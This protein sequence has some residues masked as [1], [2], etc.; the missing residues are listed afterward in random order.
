MHMFLSTIN[1][2]FNTYQNSISSIDKISIQISKKKKKSWSQSIINFPRTFAWDIHQATPLVEIHSWVVTLQPCHIKSRRVGNR[3]NGV[4][5]PK[6]VRNKQ[7]V[8]VRNQAIPARTIDGDFQ[9][10]TNRYIIGGIL[11]ISLLQ[12]LIRGQICIVI[13]S[14]LRICVPFINC[15][16]KLMTQKLA[17][18]TVTWNG[19]LALIPSRILS[20]LGMVCLL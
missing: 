15:V 3:F 4:L 13:L 16:I 14:H 11:A 2:H 20:L 1:Y 17:A 19:T 6:R 5:W 10:G 12:K 9:R 8:T 18:D 7:T